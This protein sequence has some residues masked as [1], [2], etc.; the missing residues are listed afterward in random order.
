MPIQTELAFDR[1]A[2][3]RLATVVDGHHAGLLVDAPRNL[4]AV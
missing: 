2:V 3:E 1:E 4:S